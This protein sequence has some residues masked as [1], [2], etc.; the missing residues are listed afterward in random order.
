MKGGVG[1]FSVGYFRN[2]AVSWY[3]LQQYLPKLLHQQ[4][5]ITLCYISIILQVLLSYDVFPTIKL[6]HVLA[7]EARE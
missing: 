4:H 6:D 2:L 3:I 7:W 5:I 1:C